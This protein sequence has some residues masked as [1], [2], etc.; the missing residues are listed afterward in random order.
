MQPTYIHCL[1]I[2]ARK[3]I[4]RKRHVFGGDCPGGGANVR[5]HRRYSTSKIDYDWA[6]FAGC[7]TTVTTGLELVRFGSSRLLLAP[8]RSEPV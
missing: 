2:D 1:I 3:V 6:Y 4:V 7:H 5:T 8:Q